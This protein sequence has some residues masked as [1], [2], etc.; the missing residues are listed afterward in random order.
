[1]KPCSTRLT[2]SKV[3]T[4]KNNSIKQVNMMG[5]IFIEF[6]GEFMFTSIQ[7]CTKRRGRDKTPI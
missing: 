3:T 7:D 2:I 1:M 5:N 4:Q 6:F